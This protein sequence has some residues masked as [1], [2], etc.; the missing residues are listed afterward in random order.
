MHIN[1]DEIIKITI[2][3]GNNLPIEI[4]EVRKGQENKYA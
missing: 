4:I 3:L 2:D 1:E